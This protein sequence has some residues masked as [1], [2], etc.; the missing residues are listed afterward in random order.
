VRKALQEIGYRGW[1]A[2]EVT[3]GDR[4]RLAEILQ[5]MN[6]VVGK[7]DGRPPKQL[8]GAISEE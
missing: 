6:R 5:R 2:A 8:P 4:D 1:A 7:S 3:G